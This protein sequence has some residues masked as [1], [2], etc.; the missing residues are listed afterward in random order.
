M[1]KPAVCRQMP[2]FKEGNF[3]KNVEL[4]SKLKSLAE[5]K[6]ITP[7]QLALAWVHAQVTTNECRF[8]EIELCK[9]SCVAANA[10]KPEMFRMYVSGR[11]LVALLEGL[12]PKNAGILQFQDI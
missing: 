12:S 1:S 5:K 8:Q 3:E 10:V 6:G 9:T 2:R 11:T 4:V 7:A